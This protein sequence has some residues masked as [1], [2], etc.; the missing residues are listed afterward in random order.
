[1]NTKSVAK[2]WTLIQQELQEHQEPYQSMEAIYEFEI[3][4]Q[5]EETRQ[6][7]FRDGQYFIYE[8]PDQPAECTL[9]LKEKYFKQ[10]LVGDLNSTMAFMTGKIKIDGNIG[11]ALKLEAMLKQYKFTL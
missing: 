3:T 5:P 9:K 11:L 10:F 1:M 6:L 4:D 8:E 7:E 2:W